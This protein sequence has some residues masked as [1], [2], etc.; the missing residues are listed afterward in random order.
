[1]ISFARHSMIVA[2]AFSSRLAI[3][4][5][6]TPGSFF[7]SSADSPYCFN[8]ALILIYHRLK[9]FLLVNLSILKFKAD[10]FLTEIQKTRRR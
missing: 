7:V 5:V 8:R 9:L 2:C 6:S 3:S 4:A 10:I 1:M